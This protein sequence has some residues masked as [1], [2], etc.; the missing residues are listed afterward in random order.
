MGEGD[1][2]HEQDCA[3]NLVC[4]SDNC[5]GPGFDRDDDCCMARPS[6]N[7]KI[8]IVEKSFFYLCVC[9]RCLGEL[10]RR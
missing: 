4:G 10:F 9:F 6:K 5:R 3:G 8:Q 7:G 2:D 1:C